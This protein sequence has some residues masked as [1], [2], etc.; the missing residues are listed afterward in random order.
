VVVLAAS[1][2]SIVQANFARLATWSAIYQVEYLKTLPWDDGRL[3]DGE[4][5]EPLDWTPGA[6][7]TTLVT[8][9]YEGAADLLAVRVEV[10][11][12]SPSPVVLETLVAQVYADE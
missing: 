1:R 2:R 3:A 8:R 6:T 9:N 4:T 11:W 10:A 5:V 7:R 12:G